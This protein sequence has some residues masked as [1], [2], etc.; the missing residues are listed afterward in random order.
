[1]N[2]NKKRI[3]YIA[4]SSILALSNS[5]PA[6]AYWQSDN[7]GTY[8]IND[9]GQYY[10]DGWHKIDNKDYY[11]DN[12]G[13]RK[14]GWIVEN[15]V[16]YLLSDKTGEMLTG[17][18]KID[19][20]WYYLGSDGKMV[21]NGWISVDGSWYY[22]NPDGSLKTGW[23]LDNN[24]WFYFNEDGVM[25][26]G[27]IY[28]GTSTYY[29]NTDPNK[30]VFGSMMTGWVN[31]PDD[32]NAEAW[33]YFN[34]GSGEILTGDQIIDGIS[35]NF[36]PNG[37]WLSDVWYQNKYY[38]TQ[39]TKDALNKDGSQKKNS[40]AVNK[41]IEQVVYMNKNKNKKKKGEE[42][43]KPSS[44]YKKEVKKAL[45]QLPDGFLENYFSKANGSIT[46]YFENESMGT[47]KY[48]V[49]EDDYDPD[50]DDLKNNYSTESYDS[51]YRLSGNKIEFCGEGTNVL[52]GFGRFV[53][54][55]VKS[56]DAEYRKLKK[57]PSETDEFINIYNEEVE[58][59][60]S[61]IED[62]EDLSIDDSD[63]YETAQAY[64]DTCYALYIV[65]NE[66]FRNSC[67][68]S[69][70]FIENIHNRCLKLFE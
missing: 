7:I 58:I 16:W 18:Q 11:F 54:S 45:S 14:S 30:G 6:L 24:N 25:Q 34:P 49:Y 23:L 22:C 1:M 38:T 35:Y 66:S 3:A 39:K 31:I 57:K 70:N 68:N 60:S 50:D 46:S 36:A 56:K 4:L 69:Y 51:K 33:Y 2:R 61:S 21:S 17:W 27:K 44:D 65:G 55:Y 40:T 19:N 48:K 62:V 47:V 10:K 13:Y 42:N 29:L 15:G 8:Y 26:V 9:D 52:K 41:S 59:L 20:K 63:I 12:N 64:F 5:I 28:T 37:L 32:K 67:P 53:D 43:T